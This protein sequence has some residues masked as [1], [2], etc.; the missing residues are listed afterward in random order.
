MKITLRIRRAAAAQKH[1]SLDE[2]VRRYATVYGQ[3]GGTT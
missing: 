3:L 2:G 1:F